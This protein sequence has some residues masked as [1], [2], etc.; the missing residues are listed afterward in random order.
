MLPDVIVPISDDPFTRFL[1]YETLPIED[2]YYAKLLN[3][4]RAAFIYATLILPFPDEDIQIMHAID[5]CRTTAALGYEAFSG[6]QWECLFYAGMVLGQVER[7]WIVDRCKMIAAR[8]PVLSPHVEKL[9]RVWREGRGEWNLFGKV[10]PRK[11]D[12]WFK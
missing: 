10:Y 2:H 4:W 12:T 1:Q 5:I 11:E 7:E 8:M 6:P 9:T 3:Q